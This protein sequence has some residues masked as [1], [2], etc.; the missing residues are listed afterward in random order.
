MVT[1]RY[2]CLMQALSAR[3]L[4]LAP[5]LLPCGTPRL[6]RSGV[7]AEQN[8]MKKSL[9]SRVRSVLACQA[10]PSNTATGPSGYSICESLQNN[11]GT[12]SSMF[13]ACCTGLSPCSCS[14]FA[15][16]AALSASVDAEACWRCGSN[17]IPA[18]HFFCGRCSTV[19]P[20]YPEAQAYGA[21]KM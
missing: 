15:S 8:M 13:P 7:R 1:E 4:Q 21:F 10:M 17:D 16:S 14:T 11:V 18:P 5:S 12:S 6:P 19:Q 9:L 2:N 3:L 20:V